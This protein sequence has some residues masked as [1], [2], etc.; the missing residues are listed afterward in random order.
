MA[1]LLGINSVYHAVILTG[2]V[3]SFGPTLRVLKAYGR[4]EIY[5]MLVVRRYLGADNVGWQRYAM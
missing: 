4:L 1:V 2:H 5:L 3:L